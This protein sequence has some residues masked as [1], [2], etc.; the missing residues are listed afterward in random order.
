VNGTAGLDVTDR[1][2]VAVS[3]DG[4]LT[5]TDIVLVTGA[6][7]SNSWWSYN[8]SGVASGIYP[9]PAIYNATSSGLNINGFSNI[10]ITNL[11]AISNLRIRIALNNNSNERWVI[12]QFIISGI[13]SIL[14]LKLTSF[15][16]S[17]T[18]TANHLKWKTEQEINTKKFIVEKSKDGVN[19]IGIATLAS[20]GNSTG[21]YQYDDLDTQ[22]GKIYYRLKMV[23]NDGQ[24]TYSG[25][26]V[27]SVYKDG[28]VSVYPNPVKDYSTININ[29]SLL[30]TT[31]ILTDVMGKQ[32]Q[33]ISLIQTATSISLAAYPA[34]IYML[35]LQNGEAIKLIKQ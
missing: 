12:D 10:T 27:L 3:N 29:S 28:A 16:G 24:Y 7:S 34:G 6:S 5:Y 20:N 18:K 14:P 19:F 15:N 2:R 26:I 17:Q 4:G 25:V 22:P 11:P 33:R 23:D 35:Q 21:N 8:G 31:A 13:P 1:V 32:L 30:S 9:T